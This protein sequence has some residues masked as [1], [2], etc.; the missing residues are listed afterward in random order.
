MGAQGAGGHTAPRGAAGCS[1]GSP[2]ATGA[3]TGSRNPSPACSADERFDATFHTNVLVNSSGHCQYLPPGKGRP[4]RPQQ[5]G[6]GPSG[7]LGCRAPSG[8][9]VPSRPAPP[10]LSS[11][12]ARPGRATRRPPCFVGGQLRLSLPTCAPFSRPRPVV[13][14][15]LAPH[16]LQAPWSLPLPA[17]VPTPVH[18]GGGRT[19]TSLGWPLGW[20]LGPGV[21]ATACSTPEPRVPGGLI[22]GRLDEP[23]SQPA[24]VATFPLPSAPPTSRAFAAARSV[25]RA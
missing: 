1:S 15:R 24:D 8:H 6:V 10:A 5:S 9:L 13:S 17:A 14:P 25:V 18:R 11:G 12:P 22:S 19:A 2:K 7:G 20:P 23:P 16:A 21:G 4:L 3:A